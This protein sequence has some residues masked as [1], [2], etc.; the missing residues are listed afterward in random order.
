MFN[1]STSIKTSKDKNSN[2]KKLDKIQENNTQLSQITDIPIPEDSII[3]LEKTLIVGEKSDWMGRVS[4]IS[5]KKVDD[6]YNF[7]LNEM[8]KFSYE[9]KSSN[10]S[11]TSTL[12]FEN[13]KKV[14]FIKISELNLRKTYIEITATP[15]N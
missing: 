11:D 12:I 7:F 15:V 9:K 10:K 13:N 1:C 14:I 4:L 8:I 2:V 6:I 3:D 5:K